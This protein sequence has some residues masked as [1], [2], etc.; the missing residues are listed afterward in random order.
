MNGHLYCL[1]SFSLNVM[2]VM[3]VFW[4]LAKLILI[5]IVV[6]VVVVAVVVVVVVV[7]VGV[8]V[9][10]FASQHV[11]KVVAK[12]RVVLTRWRAFLFNH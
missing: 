7:V 12:V 2:S 8:V 3:F 5:L 1:I 9:V 4:F 6:V 11:C 10:I